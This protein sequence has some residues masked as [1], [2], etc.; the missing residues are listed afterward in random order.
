MLSDPGGVTYP[1]LL[2]MYVIL[3]SDFPMPSATSQQEINEARSLQPLAYGLQLPY[4]RLTYAVTSASSRL[5]IGCVRSTLSQS[6]FQRLA[7]RR[8]VA[9]R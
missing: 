7:D 3:L 1:C 9:H 5:G 8:F 4:L 2:T 6:H